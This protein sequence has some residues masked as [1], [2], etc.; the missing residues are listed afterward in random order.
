[1]DWY[2]AIIL[3]IVE[4]ITEFLP[5]SSTGHMMIASHLMGLLPTQFLSTFEIAIQLGAI[6]AVAG[7]YWRVFLLDWEVVARIIVAFIPTAII[8]FVLYKL[9]KAVLLAHVWI[10]VVALGVGGVI[11]IIF[12]TYNKKI[13]SVHRLGEITFAQALLIGCVQSLAVVPGVSR[14]AATIIGGLCLGIERR[15]IVEFSFLLAVPTMLAATVLDILKMETAINSQEWGILAI[16]FVTSWAVAIVAVGWF[17]RF[18]SRYNFTPF[19]VY[20][21]VA[22]LI[23]WGILTR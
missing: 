19:G 3:G 20:R 17:V 7:M 4:G 12:E 6:F 14:S 1:M 15:T 8:G 11:L 16:G 5:V 22:A 13:P 23:L 9:V 2:H 21:I 18:A 10:A